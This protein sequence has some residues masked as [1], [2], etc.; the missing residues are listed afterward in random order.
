MNT[1]NKQVEIIEKQ[2][3]NFDTLID[4]LKYLTDFFGNDPEYSQESLNI[5]R[6]NLCKTIKEISKGI[7]DTNEYVYITHQNNEMTVKLVNSKI[8]ITEEVTT[9]KTMDEIQHWL[10]LCGIKKVQW[11]NNNKWITCTLDNKEQ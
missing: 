1:I 8:G 3:S 11:N 9:A 2:L 10:C 7:T 4:K 6:S 5:V